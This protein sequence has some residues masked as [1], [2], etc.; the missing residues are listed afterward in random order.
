M[1]NT[2]TGSP[3][4]IDQRRSTIME[5]N[6]NEADDSKVVT[7]VISNEEIPEVSKTSSS[8]PQND[9]GGTSRTRKAVKKT[10]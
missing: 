1:T 8:A 6:Q 4:K 5:E 2:D 7:P 9:K 3:L 10:L